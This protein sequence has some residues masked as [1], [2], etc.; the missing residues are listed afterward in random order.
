MSRATQYM[1]P[2]A[3]VIV[4]AAKMNGIVTA[5]EKPK[6]PSSTSSATGSAML[7]P[8]VRSCEKIGSRSCWVGP[9]PVT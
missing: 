4:H 7:S 1:I 9:A 2:S 3:P 6:T 8:L 5:T